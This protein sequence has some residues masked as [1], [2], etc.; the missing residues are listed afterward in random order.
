VFISVANGIAGFVLALLSILFPYILNLPADE[1][2]VVYGSIVV[3]GLFLGIVG[4]SAVLGGLAYFL[5]VGILDDF[6]AL[7][8]ALSI[9][10]AGG[11]GLWLRREV[12]ARRK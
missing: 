11:L 4:W 8:P 5:L 2:L 7:A 9:A 1:P 10:V 6:S 12:M 3:F